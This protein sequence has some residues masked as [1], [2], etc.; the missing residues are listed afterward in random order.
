M[1]PVGQFDGQIDA[2]FDLADADRVLIVVFAH[3]IEG[4]QQALKVVRQQLLAE[5]RIAPGPRNIVL[6]GQ[7][8]HDGKKPTAGVF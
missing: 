1:Q 3:M 7:I 6:G 5:L 4:G 8:A 2:F